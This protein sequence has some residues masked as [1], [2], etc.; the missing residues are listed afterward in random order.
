MIGGRGPFSLLITQVCHVIG[1][2]RSELPTY[3]P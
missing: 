2:L 3:L 1:P